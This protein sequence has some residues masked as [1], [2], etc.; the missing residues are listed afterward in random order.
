MLYP[1]SG[2]AVYIRI[3]LTRFAVSLGFACKIN[4]AAPAT[5]GVAIDVPL[6]L[7]TSRRY[8][9]SPALTKYLEDIRATAAP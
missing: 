2:W 7:I 8:H 3:S 4:D 9:T 5:S 1:L 6:I